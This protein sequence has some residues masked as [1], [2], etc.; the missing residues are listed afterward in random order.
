MDTGEKQ[1]NGERKSL[2]PAPF[3]A[4][5]QQSR[6]LSMHPGL[7]SLPSFLNI[8]KALSWMLSEPASNILTGYYDL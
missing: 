3:I 7:A 2:A 8:L 5:R 1:E 4:L 6:V